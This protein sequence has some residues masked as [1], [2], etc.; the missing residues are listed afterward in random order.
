MPIVSNS[1]PLIALSRI[2]RLDVLRDL[3]EEILVPSEVYDEL[4]VKGKDRPGSEAV[5]TAVW[6]RRRVVQDASLTAD[7]GSR[8]LGRGEADAVALARETNS[9]CL[10]DDLAAI[11]A[12]KSLGVPA[13]RTLNMLLAA[14]TKGFVPSLREVMDALRKHSFWIDDATYDQVLKL[15]GE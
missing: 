15:A 12:A 3:F 8:G 4:V 14:K 2:G 10:T 11:A 1:T 5:A 13:R 7:L 9:I 6:I